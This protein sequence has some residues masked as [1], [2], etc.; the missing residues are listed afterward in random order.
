MACITGVSRVPSGAGHWRGYSVKLA[1]RFAWKATPSKRAMG[2]ILSSS[3]TVALCF[4]SVY[5][6]LEDARA[7]AKLLSGHL[8][9]TFTE[10]LLHRNL[11]V[12]CFLVIPWG[13]CILIMDAANKNV[14]ELY[15][16]ERVA[17]SGGAMVLA[18]DPCVMLWMV[19]T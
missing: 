13:I 12:A 1:F 17:P 5:G 2:W 16:R 18:G 6:K 11:V 10:L 9:L 7:L 8:V 4:A 15:V 14:G 3:L 19:E